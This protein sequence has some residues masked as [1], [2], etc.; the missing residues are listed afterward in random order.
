VADAVDP[1][2]VDAVGDGDGPR[3]A[4]RSLDTWGAERFLSAH[5]AY[6]TTPT[7]LREG[8]AVL[9]EPDRETVW[10]T[11]GI[12]FIL[13]MFAGLL[14]ALTYGDVLFALLSALGFA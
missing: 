10:L 5:S 12:P 1:A 9:T 2:P 14:L 4:V 13:P 11:P 3:P 8:L 6:G 7:E